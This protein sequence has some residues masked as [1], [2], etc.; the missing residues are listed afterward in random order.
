M[1]PSIETNSSHKGLP[2]SQRIVLAGIPIGLFFGTWGYL[3]YGKGETSLPTAFYHAIQLF[4]LHMPL[5]EGHINWQLEVGRWAAATSA[6]L[7][8]AILLKRGFLTEWQLFLLRMTKKHVIVCGLGDVGKQLAL[9]FKKSGSKVIAIERSA[10]APGIAEVESHGI[11]VFIDD[12]KDIDTLSKVHAHYAKYVLAVCS[13][14]DT[15]IAITVAVRDLAV[16]EKSA[17]KDAVC[18]L[19]LADPDLRDKVAPTLTS[20][21]RDGEFQINVGGFDMPEMLSRL[22][23]EEHPLDFDGIKEKEL[24][25]VHLVVVGTGPLGEALAIKALQ[26]CH[27]ANRSRPRLTIVGNDAQGLIDR[28]AQRHPHVDSWYDAQPVN[29][30][31][32]DPKLPGKVV[33]LLAKEELVTVAICPG[34]GRDG[35]VESQNVGMALSIKEALQGNSVKHTQILVYLRRKS[36]FGKLFESMGKSDDKVSVHAFGLIETLCDRNTLLHEKQDCLAR[37]LHLEYLEEQEEKKKKVEADGKQFVSRP[38]HKP[39]TIL[40]EIFRESNRMAA[41]HLAVKLRAIGLRVDIEGKPGAINSFPDPGDNLAM[42][43]HE[44]WN[45]EHWLDGWRFGERDDKGKVHNNLK[46]WDELTDGEKYIDQNFV[47]KTVRIV[48][49]AKMAIYPISPKN[50]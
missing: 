37:S 43:E 22:A 20:S 4:A 24:T 35:E 17:P 47:A 26:L 7:T 21:G 42:M 41:D 34:S 15:N 3:I 50:E 5:L 1:H 8:I 29:C 12:A 33:A 44:R 25:K 14:D 9:D 28:L 36:G 10:T 30:D 31:R 49:R 2:W 46:P 32:S 13:D 11:T 40:P 18:L 27:F 39:W 6:G 19:L 45:A 23:F 16:A 48:A 38:A